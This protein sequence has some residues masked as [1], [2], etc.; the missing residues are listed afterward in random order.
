M[1]VVPCRN[2]SLAIPRPALFCAG[3][4][5]AGFWACWLPFPPT[6]NNLFSHGIVKGR[7]RRFPTARYKRWREEAV[8]RIRSAWR[9][10]EPYPVPVVIKLELVPPDHR[11]RDASNY[12]KP[13]ED[14]LVEARVLA[15]DSQNHVKAVVPYWGEPRPT[16]GVIVTIRPARLPKPAQG[17]LFATV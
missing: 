7:V 14:A 11:P 9:H 16:S 4:T 2:C 17:E 6:T 1:Q 12:V 15:D 13:V 10:R 5:A 8:I 3:C